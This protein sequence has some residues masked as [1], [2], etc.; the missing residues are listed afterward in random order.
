MIFDQNT[1]S[2]DLAKT[3]SLE[4]IDFNEVV[5]EHI[6]IEISSVLN[7]NID[8]RETFRDLYSQTFYF[9]YP[10]LFNKTD[11]M[12]FND[13]P[14]WDK[15]VFGRNLL[16]SF[17][18]YT[19]DQVSTYLDKEWGSYEILRS[20]MLYTGEE[21]DEEDT[22]AH[23]ENSP[24]EQVSPSHEEN[25]EIFEIDYERTPYFEEESTFEGKEDMGEGCS[26]RDELDDGDLWIEDNCCNT[27]TCFE[28]SLLPRWD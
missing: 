8:I 22:T 24:V 9:L 4:N 11:A 16:T 10:D 6:E 28:N 17:E 18:L 7:A 19:S 1:L 15:G 21:I 3:L 12:W 23:F 5:L 14:C 13:E 25:W 27:L 2:V 20:K 26:P